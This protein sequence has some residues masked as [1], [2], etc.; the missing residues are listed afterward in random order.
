VPD[1]SA[2][3][4]MCGRGEREI[5]PYESL[6]VTPSSTSSPEIALGVATDG[7]REEQQADGE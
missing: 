1:M 7:E 6:R 5:R 4:H 3:P 2:L